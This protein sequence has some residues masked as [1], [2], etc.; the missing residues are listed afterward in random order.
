MANEMT[1][2]DERFSLAGIPLFRQLSPAALEKM[3][4]L[5]VKLSFKTGDT[6]FLE[7]EPGDALYVVESGRVR[8]WVR[9]GDANDVT[10]SELEPGNF[11]GEMSVLDGGKRSANAAAV[12][13][14]T[15]HCLRREDFENFLI[16]HPQAGLEVIRGIGARLRQTS[17]LVFQ[18]ATRNANIVHEQSLS[19]L[20]RLAIAITDKVGSIGFFLII[21]GWTVLWTGYN[22]LASEVPALHWRAFDPFPAFVA[23]LLISNV[24]QILLMPLIMVGQNLQGR[25][26]ETRAELDFEVNQKAEKEVMATLLHLERNTDLLLRLMQ[27]LDCRV[28]DEEL[29]DIAAE[30]KLARQ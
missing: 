23:Y 24:I 25:H 7:R 16:E 29:R 5:M 10:L 3:S 6:I 2:G 28:S 19:A 13:D 21:A 30:R 1:D 15:L 11:F 18:R 8:I 22:I 9:D 14:T 26:S 27:H 20:D 12:L 4:G 17:L